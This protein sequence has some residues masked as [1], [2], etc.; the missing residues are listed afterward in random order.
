MYKN[1]VP[2]PIKPQP[3]A[4]SQPIV[5]AVTQQHYTA[6][7]EEEQQQ[8]LSQKQIIKALRKGNIPSSIPT[9]QMSGYKVDPSNIEISEDN[10]ASTSS[11][12]NPQFELYNPNQ[13]KMVS[14]QEV[15]HKRKN[16]IH[17]LLKQAHVLESTRPVAGSGSGNSSRVDAKKKYGW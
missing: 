12:P 5:S 8:P 3:S 16:Q 4:P 17:H 6:Q 10:H 11:I 15:R 2:R 1:T 13:G 7:G 14:A 9:I